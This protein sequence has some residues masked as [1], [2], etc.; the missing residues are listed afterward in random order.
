M[1][2]IEPGRWV[3]D[4]RRVASSTFFLI[5][6]CRRSVGEM[7]AIAERQAALE[8]LRGQAERQVAVRT[9]EVAKRGAQERH[10]QAAPD[11]S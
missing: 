6:S 3:E 7:W 1:L 8:V 10:R 5:W 9:A 11:G 2:L 4:A